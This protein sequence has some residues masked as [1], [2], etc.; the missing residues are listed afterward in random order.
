VIGGKDNDCVVRLARLLKS[1]QQA[2]ELTIDGTNV[3]I[4]ALMKLLDRR[5]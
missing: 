3:S 5:R 1:F 4:V 2:R